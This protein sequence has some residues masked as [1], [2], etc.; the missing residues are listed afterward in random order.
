MRVFPVL[1]RAGVKLAAER[2]TYHRVFRRDVM[3]VAVD[4]G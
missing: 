2:E 4:E 3:V 1:M